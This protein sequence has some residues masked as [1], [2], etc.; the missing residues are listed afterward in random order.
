MILLSADHQVSIV[1]SSG[2]YTLKWIQTMLK[3]YSDNVDDQW[4]KKVLWKIE[5]TEKV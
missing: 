3:I 2:D 1:S 4:L 5:G